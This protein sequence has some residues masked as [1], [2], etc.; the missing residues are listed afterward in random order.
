MKEY[1]QYEQINI[2]IGQRIREERLRKGISQCKLGIEIGQANG[3]QISKY[4][5]G[6]AVPMKTLQTIAQILK[7]D[8]TYL[9][10]GKEISVDSPK[11]TPKQRDYITR[12][13]SLPEDYQERIFKAICHFED[14]ENSLQM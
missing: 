4:E 1:L 10:T 3:N 14:I 9:Q 11:V 6:K 5:A 13:L 12:L 2:E 7:V 8:V